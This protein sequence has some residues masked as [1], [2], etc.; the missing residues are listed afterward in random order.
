MRRRMELGCGGHLLVVLMVT[1]CLQ[2][3]TRVIRYRQEPS[4]ERK[5]T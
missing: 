3:G 5:V 1:W 2:L 4:D